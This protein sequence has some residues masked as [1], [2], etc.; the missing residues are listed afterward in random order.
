MVAMEN[1]KATS[2]G[3]GLD[4]NHA[5]SRDEEKQHRGETPLVSTPNGQTV[6]G[7]KSRHIQFL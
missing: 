1:E 2:Y 6:R 4:V 3:N 7:L 5:M